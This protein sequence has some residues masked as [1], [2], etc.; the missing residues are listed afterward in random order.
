ML[1]HPTFSI[2]NLLAMTLLALFLF[3]PFLA[4]ISHQTVLEAIQSRGELRVATRQ[5]PTTYFLE[6][7]EPGGFEYELAKL[8]ADH[9][10]VKLKIIS[11]NRLQ[12]I[13]DSL[14]LNN[15]HLA[16]AGLTI[17]PERQTRFEFGPSYMESKT[18]LI[19]RS[20]NKRPKGFDDLGE[21]RL[22]VMANS[23]HA[24]LLATL[25][26][27]G[28]DW[29]V[30]DG[31]LEVLDLISRV[32]EGEL[33]YT[34]VDAT[35]FTINRAFFP[36]VRPAF[37]ITEPQPIAW[38]LKQQ[39]D[40]SLQHSLS[41]FF[42]DEEIQHAIEGLKE[43]YFSRSQRLNL[44]DN[45]TFRRHM[46]TRLP[47]LR[48]WFQQ[49][50]EET[51]ISW[52]L[53]AAIG[54]QESHWN[55]RA[56]S[57]TGVRGVMMLTQT[58]ARSLG[59]TKR[60][61]PEQSIRGGARYFAGIHKRLPERLQE[62]DRTYFALAAYNVGRGHLE[63]ARILTERA[64]K[65]PDSWEDVKAHLPLLTQA[66]WY[67]TVKHGF[68]RGHEPVVYVRNIRRY[69]H[70]L[71]LE[72]RLEAVQQQQSASGAAASRLPEALPNTL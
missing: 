33:D 59:L 36:R 63:D 70:Q 68:A 35:E 8:Y 9:L 64:G 67:K 27:E 46:E 37:T 18:Q 40:T 10:G 12:E 5:S 4:Y 24:E 43:R 3:A 51:G 58:T 11:Y 53:L 54:Y 71:M 19:Y 56:V 7:G 22:E 49:A 60:T 14:R 48:D 34:L 57:P 32:D 23:S 20:G 42:A 25:T 72:S 13:Y 28:V 30:A 31:D 38:M 44:V 1:T 16:A 65:N 2:R 55:P 62:P 45:L 47:P 61:D 69:R 15:T 39:R 21:G 52:Q 29:H 66:K 6:E 17:T 26:P 50:A 41:N